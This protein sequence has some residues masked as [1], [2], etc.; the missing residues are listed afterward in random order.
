[1]IIGTWP[2]FVDSQ[3]HN[4]STQYCIDNIVSKGLLMSEAVAMAEG[5]ARL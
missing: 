1:M 2:V 5:K 4:S 3:Y